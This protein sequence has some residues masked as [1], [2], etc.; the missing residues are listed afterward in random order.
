MNKGATGLISD[1]ICLN[2]RENWKR[3]D[4][5]KIAETFSSEE[6]AQRNGTLFDGPIKEVEPEIQIFGVAVQMNEEHVV[7][8]EIAAKGVETTE[9]GG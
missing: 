9:V 5:L 2:Q 8:L 3:H 7:T 6:Y 4:V 1:T